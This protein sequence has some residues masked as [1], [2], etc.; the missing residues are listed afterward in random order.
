M[1]IVFFFHFLYSLIFRLVPTASLNWQF[2]VSFKRARPM[3]CVQL[4]E[5]IVTLVSKL[6]VLRGALSSFC[7]IC[8]KIIEYNTVRCDEVNLRIL[9]SMIFE[10]I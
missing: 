6:S 5:H 8:S 7:Y 2:S 1:L 10:Q 4:V 9:Y 3:Q